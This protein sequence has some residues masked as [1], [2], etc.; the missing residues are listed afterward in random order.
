MK[1]RIMIKGSLIIRSKTTNL[2]LKENL[3]EEHRFVSRNLASIYSME[4]LRGSLRAINLIETIDARRMTRLIGS[5]L[6]S[7]L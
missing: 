3:T 7:Q 5:P 1:F 2:G 4:Q 6:R